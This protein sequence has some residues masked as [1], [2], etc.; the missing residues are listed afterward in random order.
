MRS[1][2]EEELALES[3]EAVSCMFESLV[4]DDRERSFTRGRPRRI[5]SR[6]REDPPEESFEFG[7]PDVFGGPGCGPKMISKTPDMV[8]DASSHSVSNERGIRI[9]ASLLDPGLPTVVRLGLGL[10][11][12]LVDLVICNE[13]STNERSRLADIEILDNHSGPPHER[14]QAALLDL[15]VDPVDIGLIRPAAWLGDQSE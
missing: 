9:R 8:T 15:I 5:R 7:K 4:H 12:Q 13:R 1:E 11:Q 2:S 14:N 10:T 3:D 6:R